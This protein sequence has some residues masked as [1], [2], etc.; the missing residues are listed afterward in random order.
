[1]NLYYDPTNSRSVAL[2][3]TRIRRQG[4]GWNFQRVWLEKE[5]VV[6]RLFYPN[7][8]AIS[9]VLKWRSDGAIRWRCK[10]L[11]LVKNWSHRWTAREISILRKL[12][13]TAPKEEI[14]AAIPG[15]EWRRICVAARYYGFKRE[16]KPYKIT[17]V[18]SLDSVRSKCYDIKWTMRDLDEECRTK[19]YFQTRGYRSEYPNFRAIGKAV[20]FFGG[21][22]VVQWP[23]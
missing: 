16:K 3:K 21:F 22:M 18:P 6:C 2:A 17:G 19:R 5:D 23:D 13:P 4:I 14:C 15:V 8:Y 7:I 11:G 12:Y 9:R 1:M 10:K 20:D